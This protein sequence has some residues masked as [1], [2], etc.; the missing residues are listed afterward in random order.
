M[1]HPTTPEQGSQTLLE[2]GAWWT[3]ASGDSSWTPTGISD[4]AGSLVVVSLEGK[5]GQEVFRQILTDGDGI[6]LDREKIIHGPEPKILETGIELVPARPEIAIA[7][8][9]ITKATA[10]PDREGLA[11]AAAKLILQQIFM[12]RF[13]IETGPDVL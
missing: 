2:P 9:L 13:K 7:R 5:T 12:V 1:F 6:R 3:P 10:F 11:G 4:K 8:D